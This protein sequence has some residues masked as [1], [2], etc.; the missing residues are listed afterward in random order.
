[1]RRRRKVRGRCLGVGDDARRA[2]VDRGPGRRAQKGD[3]P[4][5]DAEMLRL[6]RRA[7]WQLTAGLSWM[8][9]FRRRDG[10]GLLQGRPSAEDRSEPTCGE[11]AAVG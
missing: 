9:S 1:M 10:A 3:H 7:A 2:V 6:A 4:R 5:A 11:R 8:P